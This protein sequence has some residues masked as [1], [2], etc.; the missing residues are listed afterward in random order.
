[1]VV[2]TGPPPEPVSAPE[3]EPPGSGTAQPH[4]VGG[5]GASLVGS[6]RVVEGSASVV[7]GG[8]AELPGAVAP[9]DPEPL[10]PEPLDPEPLDPEPL[11]PEPLAPPWRSGIPG[12]GTRPSSRS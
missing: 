5:C 4:V 11:D 10:D 8:D 3:F 2:V 1:M 6:A 7:D 9:A 12:R